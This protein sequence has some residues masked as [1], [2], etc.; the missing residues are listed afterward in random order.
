MQLVLK[1]KVKNVIVDD[2]KQIIHKAKALLMEQY[3][4]TEPEAHHQLQKGAMDKG[5]KLAD[6]AARLL[7]TNQ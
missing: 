7:E 1:N 6:F 4:L 5:L 2:E 3:A